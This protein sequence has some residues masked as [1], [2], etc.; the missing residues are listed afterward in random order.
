MFETTMASAEREGSAQT[1]LGGAGRTTL[2]LAV[3]GGVLLGGFLLGVLAATGQMRSSHLLV[4]GT[5]LYLVGAALGFLHGA[6]LGWFGR[7]EGVDGRGFR[8]QVLLA[9]AYAPLPLAGGWAISGWIATAAGNLLYGNPWLLLGTGFG[10]AAGLFTLGVGAR[11]AWAALR[12]AY[13]RWPQ[14]VAGSAI[15]AGAFGL[16]AVAFLGMPATAFGVVPTGL[17]AL[18]AAGAL[19]TWVVGPVATATLRRRGS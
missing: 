17:G 14:R 7:D 16:L 5:V 8:R 9:A 10:L 15:V 6:V 11:C 4:T 2:A 18:L 13:A 3:T 19:T 12:A 1:G